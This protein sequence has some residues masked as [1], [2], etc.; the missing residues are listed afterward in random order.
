[1]LNS[2]SS[3]K[4]LFSLNPGQ[5]VG[6]FMIDMSLN[7]AVQL[8]ESRED[9]DEAFGLVKVSS[10]REGTP[11]LL[12]LVDIGIL[13]W[14][15]A[16][17]QRLRCIE[18]A[19]A[20]RIPGRLVCRGVV[21]EKNTRPVTYGTLYNAYGCTTDQ[22]IDKKKRVKPLVYPGLLGLF[23]IDDEC[24][25][26]SEYEATSIFVLP[27][28][29][30]PV[31]SREHVFE[32]SILGRQ[33]EQEHSAM[34]FVVLGK[35]MWREDD[36]SNGRVA[37]CC[38]RFGVDTPQDILHILGLPE[39]V[40]KKRMK[41][42]S[43][44]DEYVFNYY[45]QGLDVVFDGQ[46]HVVK[47]CV[48]HT[49]TTRHAEFGR[50]DPALFSLVPSDMY[51]LESDGCSNS[52][53]SEDGVE[54]SKLNQAIQA[55]KSNHMR[56]L[57]ADAEDTEASSGS[58]SAWVSAASSPG[59]STP[60][61]GPIAQQHEAKAKQHKRKTNKK[62]TKQQQQQQQEEKNSTFG[63]SNF[64][65]IDRF[66]DMFGDCLQGKPS[67]IYWNLDTSRTSTKTATALAKSFLYKFPDQGLDVEYASDDTLAAVYLSAT[68]HS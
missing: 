55:I 50:Y 38:I 57:L 43:N 49:N 37:G 45:K 36:S 32:S 20:S 29:A 40:H 35:G 65:T 64:Y 56:E 10:S 47:T 11:V 15:D 31:S 41:T 46:R 3:G 67:I 25:S 21:F 52:G 53:S 13:L 26:V 4:G 51:T 2:L 19:D 39:D 63:V 8:I 42:V 9:G 48:L 16:F 54:S 59:M 58:Q 7:D 66:E 18:I 68:A 30:A 14:F 34:W 5:N 23:K 12:D 24:S 33:S 28:D 1:M 44:G 61:F 17:S 62:K 60:N 27:Q 6:P 22:E